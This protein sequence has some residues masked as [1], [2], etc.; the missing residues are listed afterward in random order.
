[1]KTDAAIPHCGILKTPSNVRDS[2]PRSHPHESES[3]DPV[4]K[5]QTPDR[6]IFYLGLVPQ[7]MIFSSWVA[8]MTAV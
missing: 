7:L 8:T 6:Q 2:R 1:M 4:D 5:R 3:D